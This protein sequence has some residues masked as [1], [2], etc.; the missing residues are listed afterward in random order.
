MTFTAKIKEELCKTP[1]GDQGC[2]VAE[3]LGYLLYGN[4]FTPENLRLQSESPSV[5]RRV[6]Q[7]L[8]LA[9]GIELA[10]GEGSVIEC[11]DTRDIRRVF[12][13]FGFDYRRAPLQLNL[14]VLEEDNCKNAFLRG[15]FLM[16]GY[17]ST[18]GRGYHL[19]LVTSH[20]QVARQVQTLLLDMAMPAGY[21]Q[22]RGN[23]VLYYKASAM[24]EDFLSAA[25]ATSSSM[26]LML[27]KVERDL[28]NQVNRKVN[29]DSANLSKTVEAAA[30]QIAAIEKLQAAGMLDSLPA[31]LQKTAQIRL[32]NPEMSLSEMQELFTPPIS[33]PGLSARIRKLTKLAEEL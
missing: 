14:A 9:F 13:G 19:E 28:R 6:R 16:G 21:I 11:S 27:Q 7:M 15:A 30:R 24:I 5:R 10:G 31:P 1:S 8:F 18:A 3:C 29:C 12:D 32:Q 20:Y 4:Q 2:A 26:S 33:R 17:V 23:H 22:R 25:G